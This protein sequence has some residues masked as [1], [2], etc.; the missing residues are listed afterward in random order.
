[1][2]WQLIA[3]FLAVGTTAF[4]LGGVF[5]WKLKGAEHMVNDILEKD[6]RE[7]P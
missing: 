3:E 2:N 5:G 6:R 7:R 1:M 4:A